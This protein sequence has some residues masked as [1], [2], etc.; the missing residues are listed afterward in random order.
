MC[1][2]LNFKSILSWKRGG[3]LKS[4]RSP[5]RK[6]RGL[7][8]C[9]CWFRFWI[10]WILFDGM[11][12]SDL[13]HVLG[14]P[15]CYL[16]AWNILARWIYNFWKLIWPELFCLS[17]YIKSTPFRSAL[18]SE[19]KERRDQFGH[20]KIEIKNKNA[21]NVIFRYHDRAWHGGSSSSQGRGR[22]SMVAG[23]SEFL[24]R[25]QFNKVPIQ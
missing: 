16:F 6:T 1:P 17:L 15:L 9:F 2:K 4:A 21:N 20:I 23:F 8:Y 19:D 10:I 24:I 5:D 22:T 7:V 11:L 3:F 25:K 12:T 18:A 13:S 14:R